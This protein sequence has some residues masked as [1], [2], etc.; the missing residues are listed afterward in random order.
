MTRYNELRQGDLPPARRFDLDHLAVLFELSP[1]LSAWKSYGGQRWAP[2]CNPSSG[3]LHPTESYLLCPHL[4]GLYAGIYHYLSRDHLLEQRAPV[5]DAQWTDAFSGKGI[6]IGI[7]SIH[8]R[9]AWKYGMRAWRYCQHDCGHAIAAMSYAAAVRPATPTRPQNL[10][11]PF[12]FRLGRASSAMAGADIATAESTL[13]QEM[14]KPLM[15][16]PPGSCLIF[17]S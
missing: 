15:Y 1:G 10:L 14:S 7:S 12:S 9:E 3:D 8:W 4:P 16:T 2:R 17:P 11:L 13:I 5:D 6:L